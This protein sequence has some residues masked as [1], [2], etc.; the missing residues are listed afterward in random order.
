MPTLSNTNPSSAFISDAIASRAF[1]KSTARRNRGLADDPVLNWLEAESELKELRAL[2]LKLQQSSRRITRLLTASNHK[3]LRLT[4][5]HDIARILS[6]SPTLGEAAAPILQRMCDL[7]RYAVG[8]L[9]IVDHETA[10]LRCAAVV[11]VSQGSVAPFIEA[12]RSRTFALG[13]GLPGRV[14]ASESPIAIAD[15]TTDFSLPRNG[16][17][18]GAGLH[19]AVAF[20]V[21]NGSEFLGVM[22][23]FANE[24]RNPSHA[25]IE[26]MSCIGR[27]ISQFI[28]RRNAEGVLVR[29]REERRVAGCI[30]QRLLPCVSPVLPGYDIHGRC[31][32]A[33]DVGGDCFD[34]MPLPAGCQEH[35]GVF[36][37]DASGHGLGAALVIAE[38]RA[39]LQALC[40]TCPDVGRLLKLV[41]QR[42]VAD[43]AHD[44][45]VTAILLRLS[46]DNGAFVHAN[47][48]HWPGIVF[49][50][51]GA[52]RQRLSST[53]FPLGVDPAAEFDASD[54]VLAPGEMILLYSDGVTEAFS[55]AGEVF[56][57][58]RLIAS[59]Q[60][61]WTAP[62]DELIEGV[63][64]DL[65]RYA[66]GCTQLDDQT[67]VAIKRHGG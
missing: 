56:G 22:E 50:H 27:Q 15:I 67:I 58:E 14:W 16:I 20:P 29:L 7:F 54:D 19:G 8:V 46:R 31:R 44:G 28:E 37:A 2:T 30:Q 1:G 4:A 61:H 25:I 33:F 63:M 51:Q 24:V 47:A 65:N 42:I 32:S 35:L 36:L 62:T 12:V 60:S 9:W 17:A 48:G 43:P 10:L 49:D 41:N 23:F 66:G 55:S 45:F 11:P 5:E 53:G 34:F 38:T 18:A 39:Y 21:R 6:T 3:Q 26:V 57:M 52:A 59:V 13:A 64:G 40:M